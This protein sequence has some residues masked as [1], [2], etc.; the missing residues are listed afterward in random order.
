MEIGDRI[1]LVRRRRKITQ[2]QLAQ[3]IG[4]NVTAVVLWENKKNRR[5]ITSEN[6]RKVADALG[7]D[8][9]ELLGEPELKASVVRPSVATMVVSTAEKTLLE[10]FRS[11]PQELQLLQLAQF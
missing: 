11:F 9:A 10:L 3:A 1:R 4:T 2:L 6:L 8:V 5:G 7:V